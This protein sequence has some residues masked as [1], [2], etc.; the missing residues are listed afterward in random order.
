MTLA[1]ILGFSSLSI[2][3]DLPM[4]H[5][6]FAAFISLLLHLCVHHVVHSSFRRFRWYFAAVTLITASVSYIEP[7]LMPTLISAVIVHILSVYYGYEY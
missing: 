7:T 6:V 1:Y 3:L 4:L 5:V 2:V